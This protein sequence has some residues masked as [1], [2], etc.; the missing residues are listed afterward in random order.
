MV[1]RTLPWAKEIQDFLTSKFPI[2]LLKLQKTS[3]SCKFPLN[4]EPSDCVQPE[5]VHLPAPVDKSLVDLPITLGDKAR[6]GC[7][8]D[9][10]LFAALYLYHKSFKTVIK[11][12]INCD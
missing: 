7:S 3:Q 12:L 9:R 1:D 4:R 10:Y 8:W 6:P 2:L 11:L 5:G